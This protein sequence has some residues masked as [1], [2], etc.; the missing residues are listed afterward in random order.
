VGDEVPTGLLTPSQK[1]AGDEVETELSQEQFTELMPDDA[2][3]WVEKAKTFYRAN[4]KDI[5][6]AECSTLLGRFVGD[7]QYVYVLDHCCPV[8]VPINSIG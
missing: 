2:K 8:N 3:R 7:G 1:L 4:G 6:L 5:T